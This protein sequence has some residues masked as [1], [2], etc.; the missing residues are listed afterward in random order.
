MPVTPVLWLVLIL[1]AVWS[2]IYALTIINFIRLRQ[3]LT[4]DNLQSRVNTTARMIAWGVARP[5]AACWRR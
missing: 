3:M 1:R 2:A 5:S 4:P